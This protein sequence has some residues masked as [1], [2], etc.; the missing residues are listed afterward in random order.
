MDPFDTRK[1]QIKRERK[2]TFKHVPTRS[3]CVVL[4]VCF[5]VSHETN[6]QVNYAGLALAI[7]GSEIPKE[8]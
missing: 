7:L 1:K 3:E 2:E 5:L 4:L 6:R 8:E